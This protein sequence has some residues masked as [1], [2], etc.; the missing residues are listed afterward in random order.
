PGHERGEPRVQPVHVVRQGRDDHLLR[1]RHRGGHARAREP[2][3]GREGEEPHL[4]YGPAHRP[5]DDLRRARGRAVHR[6]G[7]TY[8]PFE[9]T[10]STLTRWCRC[11]VTT[12][13]TMAP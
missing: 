5:A 7:G 13:R 2:R 1:R 12:T 4:A 10:S 9:L 6:P 8:R 11:G 3:G